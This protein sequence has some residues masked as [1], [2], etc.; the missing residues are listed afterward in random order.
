ME[1]KLG[2]GEETGL[3]PRDMPVALQMKA[4][5]DRQPEVPEQEPLRD[6]E[7]LLSLAEGSPLKEATQAFEKRYLELAL[8]RHGSL[9]EAARFLGVHTTTLW[10]KVTQHNIMGYGRPE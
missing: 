5:L 2:R 8:A 9:R 10:R 6:Y 7:D 4:G 1:W 3:Q